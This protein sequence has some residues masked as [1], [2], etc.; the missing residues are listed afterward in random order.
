MS[1]PNGQGV[2]GPRRR[3]NVNG[4]MSDSGGKQVPNVPS[5]TDVD[6]ETCDIDYIQVQNVTSIE[7]VSGEMSDM[8][9]KQVQNVTSIEDVG[10]EMS[11]PTNV[12]EEMSDTSCKLGPCV[13]DI[14]GEMSDRRGARRNSQ[15]F[16]EL[17]RRFANVTDVAGGTSDMNG[18]GRKIRCDTPGGVKDK[19]PTV[20]QL[21]NVE[22]DMLEGGMAKENSNMGV[23]G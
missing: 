12:N 7:Y 23:S 20:E 21:N 15:K 3:T 18:C 19:R 1:E 17:L 8:G 14:S 22:G 5:G 13:E 16:D 2:G 6:G 4:E 9:Y 10:G 11:E